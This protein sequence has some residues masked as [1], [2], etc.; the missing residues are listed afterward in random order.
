MTFCRDFSS[1]TV[2][3]IG[4]ELKKGNFPNAKVSKLHT[5][6]EIR[7]INKS[8]IPK[9]KENFSV[10]RFSKQTQKKKLIYIDNTHFVHIHKTPTAEQF[11]TQFAATK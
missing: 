1:I 11:K 3:S 6:K 7:K 10:L 5:I 9:P 4:K 2:V 8:R